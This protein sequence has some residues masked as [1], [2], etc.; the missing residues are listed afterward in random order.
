VEGG[1]EHIVVDS[2]S[3]DGT[4]ELAQAYGAHVIQFPKGN[5]YA[6]INEGMKM[7]KGEWLTYLNGDDIIYA[8]TTCDALRNNSANADILYG[9]IDYLDAV[10]RFLFSWRYPSP[11]Y[12]RALMAYYCPFPQQGMLYRRNIYEKLGGYDTRYKFSADYD[13]CV[14]A[15]LS[16]CRFVKYGPKTVAGFRLLPTQLSQSH[17]AEMAPEGQQIRALL[18]TSQ[19]TLVRPLLRSWSLAYRFLTNLDSRWLRR[20]RGYSMDQR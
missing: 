15:A 2:N 11:R 19:P 14:R 13:M 4:C 6:A 16:G 17:K 10:G 20:S 9:D 7:A 18:G 12:L 3:D 1:A 8:D 5:M